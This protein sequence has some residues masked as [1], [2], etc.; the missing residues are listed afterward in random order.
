MT[1]QPSP[2]ACIPYPDIQETLHFNI[3]DMSQGSEDFLEATSDKE[4]NTWEEI[5]VYRLG[6]VGFLVPVVPNTVVNEL[7]PYI[8]ITVR[9]MFH[10]ANQ[11]SCSYI[12]IHCNPGKE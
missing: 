9:D 5:A 1:N 7:S 6:A 3:A 11:L 2:R 4:T 10:T 8:P 12:L